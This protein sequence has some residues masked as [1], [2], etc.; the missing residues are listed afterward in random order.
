MAYT[1]TIS[2]RTEVQQANL[3]RALRT[4]GR[5]KS[6]ASQIKPIN[7]LAPGNIKNNEQIK[8][9][10]ISIERVAKNINAGLK[11][12]GK[13]SATFAG[14]STQA[15]VLKQVLDN[16]NVSTK[17]ASERVETFANAF[18]TATLR[19]EQLGQAVDEVVRKAA[20]AQNAEFLF[21][22]GPSSRIDTIEA[23][24]ARRKFAE[25]EQEVRLQTESLVE[26]KRTK[27]FQTARRRL[28]FLRKQRLETERLAA[29]KREDAISGAIT[30]GA[31]PLLF[32]Q[33]PA[34]ALGG[35]LG[36][37]I[38]GFMGGG[39]GLGL[40]LAGSQ[41]G[42]VVDD[43]VTKLGDLSEALRSPSETLSA[44]EDAGYK[45]D[46]AIKEQ[47][48]TLLESGQAYEAQQLALE[49][50]NAA[51]GPDAVSQLTQ[52]AAETDNLKAKYQGVV[53]EISSKLL[54]V[55]VSLAAGLNTV[56]NAFSAIAQSP[57]FQA[58][59]TA[60]QIASLANPIGMT[61]QG[62]QY[63]G[64]QL[65]QGA[66]PTLSSEE[67]QKA[68]EII[69]KKADE[70]DKI[71]ALLNAR[72]NVTRAELALQTSGLD[73]TT[74]E[75][76][77]LAV[78]V[79]QAQNYE[80][81]QRIINANY[82]VETAQL[83]FSI[84]ALQTKLALASLNA[85]RDAA[86]AAANVRVQR[87]AVSYGRSQSQLENESIRNQQTLNNLRIK[88]INQVIEDQRLKKTAL[89][90][91]TDEI[92]HLKTRYLYETKN[93]EIS[94]ASL[95]VKEQQKLVLKN[96]FRIRNTQISQQIAQLKVEE[97]I[98]KQKLKQIKLDGDA[99]AFLKM[100]SLEIPTPGAGTIFGLSGFASNL[101]REDL[102]AVQELAQAV[103]DYN[104]QIELAT[105]EE[106]GPEFIRNL[107][108]QRDVAQANLDVFNAYAPALRE[109]ALA[110][111]T[112]NQ[113]LAFAK[114]PIDALVVGLT[115]IVD[116]TKTVQQ[117]F[118][119]FLNAIANQ[120]VQTA[121]TMI[122]QYVALA[123]ARSFAMGGAFNLNSFAS[124]ISKSTTAFQIPN[125]QPPPLQFANG[126]DPPVGKASIVGEK[127]PELFVPKTAGTIIP[128]HRLGGAGVTVGSI[129]ITVENSGE[130]LSPAAQKQIAGQVQGLVLS[131]LANERRSG[132]ML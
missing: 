64:Q 100:K 9:Q 117:V 124:D 78:K 80:R 114:A 30:G 111:E 123:I 27:S 110:Q 46:F 59:G 26:R 74:Q 120:L 75:G 5:V 58:L 121:S 128:N 54:P 3:D 57:L 16:I 43:L 34:G 36:G 8:Q 68:F 28:A 62:L 125:F 107:Q 25:E 130:S 132:G 113:V 49:Q 33:G 71:N 63:T 21:P 70:E 42:S 82:D 48:E 19:A 122:A 87:S 44:L 15:D 47:I 93:I 115:S 31:F 22:Q 98:T 129:N 103:D 32:G 53:A 116:G 73:L 94:K 40:S 89:Q 127:G 65:S 102:V 96:Q 18:V 56:A 51:L 23:D 88:Q 61:V 108:K 20:S 38:G 81:L 29:K 10:L 104:A 52:Y 99:Q 4:I 119:D 105:K 67:Q 101:L 72:L 35:G 91:L 41:L 12:P 79:V 37:A 6:L 112:Y 66:T 83:Q 126:G 109:A 131:T 90:A 118:A 2:I 55:L 84:A 97:L 1:E 92:G 39:L 69:Q 77:A 11:G 13:L 14:A 24:A 95:E 7:L 106:A 76:Y 45:V 50:V 60:N 86:V 85:K 17:G